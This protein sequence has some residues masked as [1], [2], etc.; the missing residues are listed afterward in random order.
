MANNVAE[1]SNDAQDDRSIPTVNVLPSILRKRPFKFLKDTANQHGDF[2][3]LKVGFSSL[4][5]LSN[6]KH[7]QYVLRDRQKNFAKSDVLYE[8]GR[9]IAGNGLITSSGDFWL[10]QRRMM[11]P[12]FH[13]KKI[14]GFATVMTDAIDF[15]LGTWLAPEE[16]HGTIKLM[17]SLTQITAEVTT[18]VMFGA[19]TLSPEEMASMSRDQ[20]FIIQQIALFSYLLF[21]PKWIPRPGAKRFHRVV[22]KMKAKVTEI[23]ELGRQDKDADTLLAMLIRA[24]DEETNEQMTNEQLFDEVQSTFI[25]GFE[26]TSKGLVW[27]FYLLDKHPNVREKVIQEI[28]QAVGKRT[29]TFEDIKNLPYCKMVVQESLRYYPPVA[30]LPRTSVEDDYIDGQLIPADSLI[31]LFYYGLHHHPEFWDE[32]E[33]FNPERFTKSNSE[34]RSHF[35]YLP[36]G[37]GPRQCIG[38]EFA[39]MESILV[40][41]MILQRYDWKLDDTTRVIPNLATTLSPKNEIDVNIT[42]LH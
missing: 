3:R 7:F 10:R 30:A 12:Y 6:P 20:S 11:Q 42:R 38:S 2:V 15:V 29:P 14:E 19:N 28:E 31:I 33:Q 26:T 18:K 35:S 13:R 5:L 41:V 32:P 24:V 39:M 40:L 4:Y 25:A 9:L 37:A 22:N 16:D 21:L 23:I 8:P 17:E 34:T 36:F 1:K 27:M